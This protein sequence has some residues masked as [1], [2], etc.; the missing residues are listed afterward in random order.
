MQGL[1]LQAR[2]ALFGFAPLVVALVVGSVALSLNE[3]RRL[4]AEVRQRSQSTAAGI[5]QLLQMSDA[6]KGEQTRSAMKLFKDKS[7]Q[8]GAA[9]AGE[10]VAVGNRHPVNVRFGGRGQ[11]L[12]TALVDGVSAI[13]GGSATLFAREGRDFVRIATNVKTGAGQRAVGTLLDPSGKAYAAL[14]RGEAFYGQVDILGAPYLT[15]YEPIL[16]AGGQVVGAWYVGFKADLESLK[17]LIG[18]SAAFGSGFVVL[19]DGKGQPFL[20]SAGVTPEAILA[21]LAEARR[22][23]GGDWV[24]IEAPFPAW[25]FSVAVTYRQQEVDAAG[26][27]AALPVLLAG[28]LLTVALL[29][30]LT[31]VLRRVVLGPV[32][33]AVAAADALAE[34]DLTVRLQA[35]R[36]DEIGRLINAMAHMVRRLADIIGQV[37]G[38][39]DNLSAASEQVSATA[40]S[41]SQSSSQQAASVEEIT[42][43]LVQS[44]ASVTNNTENAHSTDRMASQAATQAEAGGRAVGDSVQ[45]MRA[46]AGKVGII[47]DIA[48]QTNL[49]ALNAAIEA[50]RA[51]EYG[52]GFAVVAAEVRKL[53]ERSQVAAAEIGTVAESTVRQAEQAGKLLEEIVPAIGRTS[54]LVREIAAASEEQSHGI[55][56]INQAMGHLNQATQHNASASEE[57]AATAEEMGGQAESLQQ[58]MHF[59]KVHGGQQGS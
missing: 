33:Q 14:S 4:E 7:A 42:A 50:A 16:D 22:G 3:S 39:A 38:A 25:G 20:H 19:L 11:G 26:R 24:A 35:E 41:L 37:R 52:K 6:L 34:G 57:L 1:G 23:A 31:F 56:Q 49:L 47:D 29:G 13:A 54:S 9:S 5:L 44:T 28:L 32:R 58:L 12:E 53:A 40:Q 55:A 30:L 17:T 21:H 51:G 59:F 15:G 48:Y 18:Q 45:A 27:Q 36:D 8:L 46:I 10:V 43:T 2:F